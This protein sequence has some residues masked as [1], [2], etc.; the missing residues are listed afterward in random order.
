MMHK[1]RHEAL[2]ATFAGVDLG[3][4]IQYRGVQY[5]AVH[6]RFAEPA[7]ID[8][9]KGEDIDC[10]KWGPR[11]PQIKYDVGH[12]LRAPEGEIFYNDSEDEFKCLNL[13]LTVPK[14]ANK[15]SKLPVMIWIHGGSQIISFGNGAS[16]IGG[17]FHT[18]KILHS[19][20]MHK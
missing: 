7:L 10:T 12:L 5:G 18:T 4:C 8:D 17:M 9:W 1:L 16:K 6:E 2:K 11:C 20:L 3:A 15:D 13:D 19:L 14:G